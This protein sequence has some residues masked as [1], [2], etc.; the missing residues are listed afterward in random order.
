MNTSKTK[1]IIFSLKRKKLQFNFIFEGS[2]LEIVE[3]YKY[4]GIDFHNRLSWVTYRIKRI[5][6]GWRT[7]FLLQ[8]RCRKVEV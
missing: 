1:V 6:G 5:Q 7:S 2:A 4:L 3:E 8:K